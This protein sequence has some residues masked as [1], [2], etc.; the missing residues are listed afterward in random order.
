VIFRRTL[1]LA[2]ATLGAVAASQLP[3]FTQQYSQRLGG[4]IDELTR[5][6]KRFDAD[7]VAV[8]E[9]RQGALARLAGSSDE[10]ARRQSA[11]MA[12]NIARLGALQAQQ[13]EMATAGPFARIEAFVSDPDRDVAAATWRAF[14]PAVP[15]TG[16]GAV[17]GGA[18]FLAG[19]G[20]VALIARLFRRRSGGVALR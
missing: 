6:V 1:S 17:I 7:S 2:V 18:G 13:A 10:L 14:E 20:I 5:V 3:E 4:A 19:G 12:S 9:T 15:T 8:N 16:E 11:A